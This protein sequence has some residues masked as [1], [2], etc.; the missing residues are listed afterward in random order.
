MSIPSEQVPQIPNDDDGDDKPIEPINDNGPNFNHSN[1]NK[2]PRRKYLDRIFDKTE[3]S[4]FYE[5]MI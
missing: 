2:H 4:I 3:D 5:N 1:E